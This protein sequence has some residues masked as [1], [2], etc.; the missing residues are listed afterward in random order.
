M[1]M[2]HVEARKVWIFCIEIYHH[3]VVHLPGALVIL[4]AHRPVVPTR[5][6][7]WTLVVATCFAKLA[8]MRAV[9]VVVTAWWSKSVHHH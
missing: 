2:R 4:V 5:S 6:T 8:E 3:L 1:Y 9:S 7:M